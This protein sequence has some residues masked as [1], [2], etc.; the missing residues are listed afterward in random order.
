MQI[1]NEMKAS[2]LLRIGWGDLMGDV[3]LEEEEEEE[4]ESTRRWRDLLA[5]IEM[6]RARKERKK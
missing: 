6:D 1:F 4:E 3:V 2:V 5:G